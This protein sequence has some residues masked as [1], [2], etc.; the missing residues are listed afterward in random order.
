MHGGAPAALVAEAVQADGMFVARLTCD[1]LGPVPIG[2]LRVEARIV[3]PG[4]RLQL[5][6]AEVQREFHGLRSRPGLIAAGLAALGL[7]AAVVAVR[8][9]RRR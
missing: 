6:E 4:R 7:G 3:R 9:R 2:P 8:R 5:V 1:F